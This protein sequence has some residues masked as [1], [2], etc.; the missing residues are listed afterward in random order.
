MIIRELENKDIEQKINIDMK[1][2][3]TEKE[4]KA[5]IEQN[6]LEKNIVYERMGTKNILQEKYGNNVNFDYKIQDSYYKLIFLTE[7]NYSSYVSMLKMWI[8]NS[9]MLEKEGKKLV[10]VVD[11]TINNEKTNSYKTMLS[12]YGKVISIQDFINIKVA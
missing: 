9:I 6:F 12:E 10:F 11:D 8:A 3:I 7:D 2:R 5:Y 1:K 4:S